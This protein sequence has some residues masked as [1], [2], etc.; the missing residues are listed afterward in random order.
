MRTPGYF[1]AGAYVAADDPLWPFQSKMWQR[2]GLHEYGVGQVL[3]PK[4]KWKYYAGS[5]VRGNPLVADFDGDGVNEIFIT[6]ARSPYKLICLNGDG[7]E[8][9]VREISEAPRPGSTAFDID[10]D[11]KFE[12]LVSTKSALLCL[13]GDGTQRWAA[14]SGRM[15]LVMDIDNDG[16]LEIMYAGSG[17]VY[18]LRTDGSVKWQTK[19]AVD[20]YYG[21]AAADVDNDGL[22]E[23]F[24]ATGRFGQHAE[25]V[26]LN[27]DG[28][29]RWR[30]RLSE[31]TDAWACGI[32]LGDI[33]N[34]GYKEILVAEY[35][36]ATLFAF[37]HDGTEI[38]RTD[39]GWRCFGLH[40]AIADIDND[41]VVEVLRGGTGLAC[42]DG[43]DGHVKWNAPIGKVDGAPSVA[44]ID[45]DG[46]LEIIVG[47]MTGVLHCLRPD[48]SEKWRF[49]TGGGI[50]YGCIAIDDIDG[51]GMVELLVGSNDGYL[52]ALEEPIIYTLTISSTPGGITEPVPGSYP[53][54]EGKTI[55]VTAIPEAGYLFDHWEGDIAGSEN[56]VTFIVTQDITIRAVFVEIL[57]PT[58]TIGAIGQGT[59]D[60]PPGSWEYE[61]G[62]PVTV[63]ALPGA[64]WQFDHWEGDIAGSENPATFII[65]ADMAITAVFS[66]IIV[67]P[68]EHA[69]TISI[70]GEGTT[71]PLP[72]AYTVAVGA[73][74]TVTAYPAKGWVF[75]HWEG[76]VSGT[77][78]PMDVEVLTDISVVAVFTE[79]PAPLP[80][81]LWP[82]AVGAA[83]FALLAAIIHKIRKR[84]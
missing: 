40:T 78:N 8:R 51:D 49:E 41:G 16:F 7:T 60:P 67:P 25:L 80:L 84:R 15:P 47:A 4:V 11:G 61:D 65:T 13:N 53:H 21:S 12:I 70:I 31:A 76:D 66:E 50:E 36:T 3:A 63:S 38:W 17:T 18:C 83:G 52:Y 57:R 26:C 2:T 72:G 55:E 77:M 1:T 37:K 44:D 64:G 68:E 32:S 56:P 69:V 34:D 42:L 48:G 74:L 81:P 59:T 33:D 20:S 6:T 39:I 43:R 9:W 46:E 35:V 75:D 58:L 45:G 24:W 19:I 27:T 23:T 30:R 28:T 10:G 54:I 62:A 82:F 71:D 5:D 14:P 22:I 29:E 73:I 79:K